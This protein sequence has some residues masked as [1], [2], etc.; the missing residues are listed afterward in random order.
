MSEETSKTFSERISYESLLLVWLDRVHRAMQFYRPK[1][2]VDLKLRII[3]F[4]DAVLSLYAML[5]PELRKEV[6]QKLGRSPEELLNYSMYCSEDVSTCVIFTKELEREYDRKIKEGGIRAR[7]EREY[8]RKST[9]ILYSRARRVVK[10]IIEV[11]H[12][13]NMLLRARELYRGVA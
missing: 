10:I 8:T 7:L 3:S 12:E 13:H 1:S 4:V 11:L 9:Q 2:S 6:T 5:I